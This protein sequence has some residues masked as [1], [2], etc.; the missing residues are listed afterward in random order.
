M[1]AHKQ[2]ITQIVTSMSYA[3]VPFFQR[4]Y[5]WQD[6]LW[7]RF[8]QDMRYLVK[9]NKP[10]FFGS[11]ILKN[12]DKTSE[13]FIPIYTIVDGQQRLT[14]FLVFYKVLCLK[15]G[16]VLFDTLFRIASNHNIAVRH[17]RNDFD[18]FNLVVNTTKAECIA[19]PKDSK[20]IAAFNYFMENIK[21]DEF[22]SNDLNKILSLSEFVKITLT[23]DEDEQ[24]IFD[25]INSLGVSLTTAELLKNY[26]FSR[27]TIKDYEEKW[28]SVFEAD[29]DSKKYWE[30]EIEAGKQKRAMIDIFFDAYFQLFIQDSKTYKISTDDKVEYSRLDSL[31]KSYQHFIANYCGGDKNVILSPLKDYATKFRETFEPSICEGSLTKE[32]GTERLN[33]IIF[34]LKTTTLIPYV[35]YCAKNC[36]T[37]ELKKICKILEC[38]IM[39]RMVTKETTKNY[40]RLFI[41]LI[42]N[43]VLTADDLLSKLNDADS[44]VFIPDDKQRCIGFNETRLYNLSAQ[45]ILYLI[46]SYNRPK[47]EATQLLGFNGYSLEHLMPKKWRN[48]WEPC[49]SEELSRERD[50]KLQ[51]LGNLAIITQPLN[52]SIRD[53]DWKTKKN[54]RSESKPGLITCA[55]GLYT[56]RD[57]LQVDDWNEKSITDRADFLYKSAIAVWNI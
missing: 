39:R 43:H 2:Q 22:T 35:L 7:E 24:E 42:A 29:D 33:V 48:K 15:L 23:K 38:F 45:G 20:V 31:A 53:S 25:T 8:L 37:A 30:Q 11:I 46:E 56:M 6:D 9:T 36:D 41:T 52:S 34:G 12:T 4:A 14:T 51:T 54:G 50:L 47:N 13:D 26:F 44:N 17:G 57:A 55:S 21:A 1:D 10:H 19:N 5:V 16:Q 40:N 27:D 32:Y 28:E 3:D 49:A 18:A